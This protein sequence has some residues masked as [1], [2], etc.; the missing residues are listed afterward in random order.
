MKISNKHFP[1]GLRNYLA[2]SDKFCILP[3]VHLHTWPNNK[4][5][6]CCL[7]SDNFPVGDL[8]TQTLEEVW[9]GEGMKK[10]RKEMLSG[11]EPESCHRCFLQEKHSDHSNRTRMNEHFKHKFS[12]VDETN[13]DG[14]LE[15][16]NLVYW[17]FRFSNI[18][19]FK[20]RSCGP[21]LS[22]GWY[23][24]SKKLLGKLPDDCNFPSSKIDLWEQL[25]PQFEYVEEIYFAGGEP[26]LMEEHYLILEKLI[27]LGK[28]DV[29]IRYNTNLSRLQYKKK[30]VLDYWNKF[31]NVEIW[32]SL[33][34][35]KERAEYI[36]KGTNWQQIENNINL[37]KSNCPHVN[38]NISATLGVY[39]AYD[40][41][42]FVEYII[43]NGFVEKNKY[44]LNMIQ[45][46]EYLRIQTLPA[47][48]KKDLT[49]IY[50]NF[51]D[52]TG[53]DH[54]KQMFTSLISYMNSED[55]TRYLPDLIQHIDQLDSIRN[56]NFKEVFPEY[57]RL[58]E[59][60]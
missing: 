56:E 5:Y 17:D 32:A 20:C 55:Y 10:L 34:S 54:T 39:N 16:M 19:N 45:T 22:S 58:Q 31:S 49:E 18:C 11:I 53:C 23:E 2:M 6:P 46:P 26:L 51:I 13:D 43:S 37:I 27:E 24:D 8:S 21:Q 38:F 28:T 57:E 41:V 50:Q 4:V 44:M 15:R 47:H 42:N 9:N 36:R 3:W 14:S 7:T 30:N 29:R 60:V 25:Q 12:V 35:F 48:Y 1:S 52:K 40:I 59:Y 33:D